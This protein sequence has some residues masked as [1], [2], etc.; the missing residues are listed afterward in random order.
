[1]SL[2]NRVIIFLLYPFV[3][4]MLFLGALGL[5]VFVLMWLVILWPNVLLEDSWRNKL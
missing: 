5:L 4:A 1:M 3:L 2:T